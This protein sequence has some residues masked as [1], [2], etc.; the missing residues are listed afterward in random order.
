VR[1]VAVLG[2]PVLES[3]SPRMHNAAFAARGLDWSYMAC[4]VE[5]ERLEEAVRGLAALGFVGANVTIP[6]K[7]AVLDLCDEIDDVAA[8]AESVNTLLFRDGRILGSS[9]DGRVVGELAPEGQ[10]ALVL[11][12]GGAAAAVISALRDAGAEVTVAS[13]RDDTWPPSGDG[14]GILVNATPVKDELIVAPRPDQ[15]VLDLA[16][17]P[18]GE[19]TALIVAAREAGC[20]RVVDGLDMLVAQ[21]AASFER[22]TGVP[23]PVDVMRATVRSGA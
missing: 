6:H 9:T 23:A 20:V 2:K 4:E 10:R 13:R 1:L 22:W 5:P 17:K 8:R 3:L 7:R 11:G 15:Q 19:P 16:Y 18:N 14:F 21:G 12:A